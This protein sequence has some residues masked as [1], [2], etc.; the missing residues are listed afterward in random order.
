MRRGYCSPT[1]NAGINTNDQNETGTDPATDR[2]PALDLPPPLAGLERRLDA[3][4]GLIAQLDRQEQS[5]LLEECFTR[6]QKEKQLAD[7]RQAVTQLQ[8]DHP[9][10]TG[11]T[12]P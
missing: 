6:A 10:R 1:E 12:D 3:L 4:L 7:L 8:A 9:S 11:T 5:T 2:A